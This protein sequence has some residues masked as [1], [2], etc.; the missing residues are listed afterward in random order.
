MSLLYEFDVSL[1]CSARNFF[2]YEFCLEPEKMKK[3]L[4][5]TLKNR[6]LVL[7]LQTKGICNFLLGKD[8]A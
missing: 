4:R 3:I 7:G 8:V 1:V 5:N 2:C 6:S